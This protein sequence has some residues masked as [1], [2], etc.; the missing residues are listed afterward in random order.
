MNSDITRFF[1]FFSQITKSTS[2]H[3]MHITS[4]DQPS[5]QY[6]ELLDRPFLR[7]KSF[8]NDEILMHCFV[9][10][11][12]RGNITRWCILQGVSSDWSDRVA[13]N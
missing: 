2:C 10:T 13:N 5:I 12:S 6:D 7:L 9:S 3:I 4:S 8:W 11:L 1:D